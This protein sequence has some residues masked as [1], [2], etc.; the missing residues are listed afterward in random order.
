MADHVAR[1]L[2][3]DW[4]NAWLAAIGVT[5]LVPDVALAWTD[6]PVPR[7]CFSLPDGTDLAALV[8]DALP[9]VDDI[10][11]MALAGLPQGISRDAF[12][13]AAARARAGGDGSLAVLVT[14]LA[15]TDG[16]SLQKGSFNVGAEG[17]ASLD[18]RLADCCRHLD[19][20]DERAAQVA[21][22]FEGRGRRAQVN[23]L[24]FD[25]RRLAGPTPMETDKLADPV[26]EVLAFHG[27]LLFPARGDGRRLR[28]RGWLDGRRHRF[29]WPTWRDPLD[30]WAIDGLLDLTYAALAP[31]GSLVLA[32]RRPLRRLARWGVTGLYGLVPFAKAGNSVTKGYASERLA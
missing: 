30:R 16:P 1:G 21:A 31:N 6:D 17:K 3:A 25:Y 8:A 22:T 4:L 9:T 10:E 12:G 27:T 14:D 26:A 15:E 19:T 18:R 5:V 32:G 24:G 23:G 2:G 11:A 7:A 20:D 28:Q 13:P 29:V